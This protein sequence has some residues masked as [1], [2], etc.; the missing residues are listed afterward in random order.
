MQS[1]YTYFE[2]FFYKL[3]PKMRFSLN[4][5]FTSDAMQDIASHM[6][7][8]FNAVKNLKIKTKDLIFWLILRVFSFTRFEL[9]HN[10]LRNVRPYEGT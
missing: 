5:I 2:W 9:R 4:Q 6:I 8:F 1:F 3:L 7:R 10:F